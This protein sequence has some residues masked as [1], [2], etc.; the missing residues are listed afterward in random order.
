MSLFEV[1]NSAIHRV[2]TTYHQNNEFLSFTLS[3]N[4]PVVSSVPKQMMRGPNGDFFQKNYPVLARAK[5]SKGPLSMHKARFK[6]L[7]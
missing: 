5:E 2:A 1:T 3:M 7:R 4:G 6:L